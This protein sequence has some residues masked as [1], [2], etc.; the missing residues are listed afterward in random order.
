MV[1]TYISIVDYNVQKIPNTMVLYLFLIKLIDVIMTKEKWVETSLAF[2]LFLMVMAILYRFSKGG[3]GAGDVKLI[4]VLA[5]YLGLEQTCLVLISSCGLIIG[6]A[7]IRWLLKKQHW[8][9]SVP[10]APFVL[11]GYIIHSAIL[12]GGI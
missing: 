10:M 4:A 12:L 1:L 11:V 5:F 8:K 7:C 2:T 3:L 9:A 6:Y